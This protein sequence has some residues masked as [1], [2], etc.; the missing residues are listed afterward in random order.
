VERVSQAGNQQRTIREYNLI[1][2]KKIH[3]QHRQQ[4]NFISLFFFENNDSRLKIILLY[5]P[6]L[7]PLSNIP[8]PEGQMGTV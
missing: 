8:L 1:T 3:R 4:G 5:F 6:T 2:I 7:Y